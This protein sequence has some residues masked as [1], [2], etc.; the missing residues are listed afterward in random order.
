MRLVNARDAA[1]LDR[2]RAR[3]VAMSP[4]GRYRSGSFL[5]LAPTCR[6]SLLAPLRAL[7]LVQTLPFLERIFEQN[8]RELAN[9]SPIYLRRVNELLS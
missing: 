2:Q 9:S 4:K 8:A 7:V 3:P 6:A 5:F 1:L